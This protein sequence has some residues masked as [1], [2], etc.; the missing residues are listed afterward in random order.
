MERVKVQSS[1]IR[2]VGYD[3]ETHLLEIEFK[4]RKVGRFINISPETYAHLISA[5]SIGGYFIEHI[6]DRYPN[7]VSGI[8]KKKRSSP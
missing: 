5:H 2:S 4:D 1:I 7:A 6:R 3:P 8:H